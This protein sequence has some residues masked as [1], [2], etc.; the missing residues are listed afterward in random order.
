MIAKWAWE[1]TIHG[2]PGLTEL[3]PVRP[4]TMRLRPFAK[5]ENAM[6]LSNHTILNP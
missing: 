2:V 1:G 6:R 4:Y 3:I 5:D